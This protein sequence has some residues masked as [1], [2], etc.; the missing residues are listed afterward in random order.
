MTHTRPQF[1]AYLQHALN[2][3]RQILFQSPLHIR[4]SNNL[5]R[6]LTN[7]KTD[8][9]DK[10]KSLWSEHPEFH[11]YFFGLASIIDGKY[12]PEKYIKCL[13]H[14][15]KLLQNEIISDQLRSFIFNEL[16]RVHHI[17]KLIVKFYLSD[18][19][20]ILKSVLSS[21]LN[22]D[23]YARYINTVENIYVLYACNSNRPE[24]NALLEA[25]AKWLMEN[26]KTVTTPITAMT[27]QTTTPLIPEQKIPPKKISH[28][29]WYVEIQTILKMKSSY[30]KFEFRW[31]RHP[32]WHDYFFGI[33]TTIDG[34]E[35][36]DDLTKCIVNIASLG[37]TS[38]SKIKRTI[39][40]RDLL[41]KNKISVLITNCS[42]EQQVENLKT[43]LSLN[44]G[45]DEIYKKFIEL[46][47]NPNNNDVI[48]KCCE[49]F[50]DK[51]KVFR[52]LR[53][54]IKDFSTQKRSLQLFEIAASTMPYSHL[55]Q[56]IDPNKLSPADLVSPLA[57]LEEKSTT[58][59]QIPQ[60][61]P[62]TTNGPEQKKLDDRPAHEQWF[63]KICKTLK[64]KNSNRSFESL[65]EENTDWQDY[66]FGLKTTIN[67][68]EY[69]DD[70]NI[71]IKRLELLRNINVTI[72]Q[73]TKILSD[74]LKRNKIQNLITN[75]TPEK[76]IENLTTILSLN[77]GD[78][79]LYKQYM[80]LFSVPILTECCKAFPS[81]GKI[82][83]LLKK[84]ISNLS[85]EVLTD[86]KKKIRAINQKSKDVWIFYNSLEPVK[87]QEIQ[88]I[89][90]IIHE[91]EGIL[92]RENGEREIV[93]SRGYRNALNYNINHHKN[94]RKEPV[95]LKLI[96]EPKEILENMA[97]TSREKYKKLEERRHLRTSKQCEVVSNNDNSFQ[98]FLKNDSDE[99]F[100]FPKP[101]QIEPLSPLPS[102]ISETSWSPVMFPPSI[103]NSGASQDLSDGPEPPYKIM[104]IS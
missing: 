16:L 44:L 87:S 90:P 43:I 46:F 6:Y 54:A 10:I 67:G 14:L 51:S 20:I 62:P 55:A 73:R 96:N 8:Y 80:E 47:K 65:W 35:Y 97:E 13:N 36:P 17:E 12:E 86:R 77:F 27:P 78:K 39:I 34:I 5:L 72:K 41:E 88:L 70:L 74:L 38:V 50:G 28:T 58:S 57:F 69:P 100:S 18:Q 60:T 2:T 94:G 101:L 103:E 81:Q 92:I 22:Q 98:D 37:S 63:E 7:K 9:S 30:E 85:R 24:I 4:W 64:L 76:Q 66:F 31:E 26:P 99:E 52:I 23:I 61:I 102:F 1:N 49:F 25:R 11:A 42:Q 84:V 83:K 79:N 59:N 45:D 56:T 48:T 29:E 93:V 15:E 68:I 91:R 21:V 3:D 75:C 32:E 104:K 82:N 53:A 40:M 89:I 19:I 33:K 95:S 71:F